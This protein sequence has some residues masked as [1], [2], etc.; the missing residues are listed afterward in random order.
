MSMI[1]KLLPVKDGSGFEMDGYSIWGC[2]V[3]KDDSGKYCM[4]AARSDSFFVDQMDNAEIVLAVTDSLDRPFKYEKTVI[5]HREEKYWDGKTAY[6]PAIIKHNGKYILFYSGSD[7]QLGYAVSD[8]ALGPFERCEAPISLSCKA[9]DPSV[10]VDMHGMLRLFIRN[11]EKQVLIAEAKHLEGSFTLLRDNLFPL[12]QVEDMFVYPVKFGFNM[13]AVDTEGMYGGLKE[14]GSIFRSADGLY[15]HPASPALAY[16]FTVELG[17]GGGM[18]LE[19]RE[20]PVVYSDE[21]GRYLFTA[22]QLGD[23]VWNMV[24]KISE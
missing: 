5:P 20:R 10:I 7:G 4:Y 13:I 24:Q 17:S 23:R 14:A 22:S 2:A 21:T 12:G 11:E 15:W 16:S 1:K 19:R 9:Y 8:S 3:I 6:D 18:T